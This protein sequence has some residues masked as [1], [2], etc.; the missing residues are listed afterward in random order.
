MDTSIELTNQPSVEL[1][2]SRIFLSSPRSSSTRRMVVVS[3][4]NPVPSVSAGDTVRPP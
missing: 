1:V 4:K 2:D 3:P